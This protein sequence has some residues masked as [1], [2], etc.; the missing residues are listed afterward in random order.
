MRATHLV[1]SQVW[2]IFPLRFKAAEKQKGFVRAGHESGR[3]MYGRT[4]R[5]EHP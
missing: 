2:L 5:V 4:S 1:N 3:T